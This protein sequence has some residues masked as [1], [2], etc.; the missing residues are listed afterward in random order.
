[1]NDLLYTLDLE[2]EN[3]VMIMN[4][5]LQ[6]NFTLTI[7]AIKENFETNNLTPLDD[8]LDKLKYM[9]NIKQIIA[10]IIPIPESN[11]NK[12]STLKSIDDKTNAIIV[13]KNI[14]DENDENIDDYQPITLSNEKLI[15]TVSSRT[16]PSNSYYFHNFSTSYGEI[17]NN[18]NLNFSLTKIDDFTLFNSKIS[19]IKLFDNLFLGRTIKNCMPKIM[20]L[21]FQLNETP[22]ITI[23]QKN[24]IYFSTSYEYMKKPIELKK[25]ECYFE[26]N[27]SENEAA[28]MIKMFLRHINIDTSACKIIH[29]ISSTKTN[30]HYITT[31]I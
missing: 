19:G 4:H 12:N 18:L 30:E 15:S 1:M 11:S 9:K 27:T 25:G 3:L 14:F 24:S 21:L 23:C 13:S 16:V 6:E 26:S 17:N 7:S 22:F 2:D 29:G 28:S 5:I 20:S 31:I 8:L 10:G